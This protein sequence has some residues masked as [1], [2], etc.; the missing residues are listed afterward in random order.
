MKL[1]AIAVQSVIDWSLTRS[2]AIPR[3]IANLQNPLAWD[4]LLAYQAY[5]DE[6]VK[7]NIVI[8]FLQCKLVESVIFLL[9]ENHTFNTHSNQ[10]VCDVKHQSRIFES[11]CIQLNMTGLSHSASWLL[12]MWQSVP[13]TSMCY[14]PCNWF[15]SVLVLH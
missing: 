11:R 6:N 13:G 14:L 9:F 1:Y 12:S 8:I 3:Q 15:L 2:I 4:I 10:L 7:I 5:Q